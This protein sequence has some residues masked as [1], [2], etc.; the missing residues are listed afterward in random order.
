MSF[1]E[2]LLSFVYK[3]KTFPLIIQITIVLTMFFLI[4]TFALIIT[5]YTIRKKHNRVQKLLKNSVPE[6][7]KLFEV[8]LFENEK[9]DELEFFERFKDIVEE[10]NRES[11]DLAVDVLVEFKN[12]HRESDMYLFIINSLGIVEHLERK[13]DSRSNSEKMD[14]FQE[15]FVLNLNKFDSKILVHAYSK[16]SQIRNEARN[17]Y[18]ALSTNDPYRF[19][20]EYS[21][22]LT[23]WD[24]I[25]LMQYLK[26]QSERGNLEGLGKW[27]NY[28]K[29]DSLVVFLIKMVGYFKQKGIDEILLEKLED[30]NAKIRAEAILTLGELGIK[31][32]EQ[33]L[34]ERYY[35][36][37]EIC[38]VSIVKTI[39]KFNTGK[40]LKFL[41]EIFSETNNTD[42]KKIIGE[43]ILN[44]SYEGK[45]AFQNLKNSLKGFDLTILKHIET[46]L[47]KY[48]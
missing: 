34:I 13:F 36:E 21:G 15:A 38:Q 29:N 26:L 24:E 18:L 4:S 9:Y 11:L 33:T 27:I 39:K 31:E 46:P 44:Y 25:E 35:T 19:F 17:S 12:E 47:I 42:T 8:V 3:I 45:I 43:A 1:V 22:D 6:I 32:T 28:S 20:D 5:I 48:K 37:P 30:D 7:K 14:A 23:K 16:N 40:S 2:W 10:V 41:Q